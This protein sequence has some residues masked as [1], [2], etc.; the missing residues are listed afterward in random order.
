MGMRV[1]TVQ[2]LFGPVLKVQG[3]V[4]YLGKYK[5]YKAK[6]SNYLGQ[7]QRYRGKGRY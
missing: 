1:E 4:H 3:K 6:Y 2:Y 7:Y 5:P